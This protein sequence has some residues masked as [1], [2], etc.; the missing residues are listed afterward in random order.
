MSREEEKSTMRWTMRAIVM[1]VVVVAAAMLPT[2]AKSDGATVFKQK[3]AVCH[4]ADGKGETAT[5]KAN[6][7]RDL[8]SADVQK[9]SDAELTTIIESGK[10][11]MPAYGK[12]LT[13]DQVKE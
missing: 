6:K 12:N 8:R 10:K 13:P 4:G 1:T 2:T 9:Q 5:G 3:C 11:K 7:L